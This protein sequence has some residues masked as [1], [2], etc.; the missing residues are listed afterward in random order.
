MSNYIQAMTTTGSKADAEQIARALVTK[1]LAAC[2]QIIG[3]LTSVYWW[4]EEVETAE[5]WL[6]LIKSKQDHY[7]Q[8]EATIQQIHPYDTPEIIATPITLGS[9][10]YLRWIDEE[11]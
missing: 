6:C 9:R 2:V 11:T 3:P 1:R 10:D 8:L 5:E 4:Q 7:P